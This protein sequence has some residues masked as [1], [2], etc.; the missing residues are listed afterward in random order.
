MVSFMLYPLQLWR[1]NL[2]YPFDKRLDGLHIISGLGDEE[3]I[4]LPAEPR[5]FSPP[6][7]GLSQVILLR[8]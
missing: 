4:L 7:T 2:W 5:S 1:K 8:S 3:K 6:L